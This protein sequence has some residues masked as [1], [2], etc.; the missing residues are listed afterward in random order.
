MNQ[1]NSHNGLASGPL[2]A[3]RV[4]PE[5]PEAL[6]GSDRIRPDWAGSDRIKPDQA[7]SSRTDAEP[8][9]VEPVNRHGVP[10][11]RGYPSVG[12][13]QPTW[14][15]ERLAELQKADP[16]VAIIREWLEAR[17]EPTRDRVMPCSTQVK[18]Y[19]SQWKSLI[20]DDGVVYRK[21]ARPGG[22]RSVLPAACTQIDACGAYGANTRGGSVLP[23]RQENDRPGP[24][25]S[26]FVLQEIRHW[27]AES[28]GRGCFRT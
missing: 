4:R 8:V 27:R 20:V 14:T 19:V 6:T 23:R 18:A 26:L 24:W 13:L 10:D 16:Y 21:F 17:V 15:P 11:D 7:G 2:R 12:E 28:R 5:R 22:G 9:E 3:D 25:S 1:V